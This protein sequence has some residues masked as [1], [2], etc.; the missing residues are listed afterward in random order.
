MIACIMMVFGAL[1]EYGIILYFM[2]QKQKFSSD[3][4]HAIQNR[5]E[6]DC[7]LDSSDCKKDQEGDF[8]NKKVYILDKKTMIWI[9]ETGEKRD[10]KSSSG[11]STGEIILK[12]ADS[13]SLIL[14]SSLFLPF[15][16]IY[17]ILLHQ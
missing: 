9:N 7:H 6:N 13:F 11:S 17:S 10:E 16:I 5:P 2:I 1:T 8:V 12:N 14:F 15:T 4:N 3:Y